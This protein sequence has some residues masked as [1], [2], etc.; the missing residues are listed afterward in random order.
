MGAGYRRWVW[1]WVG[2]CCH[3]A[4]LAK[5]LKLD[6]TLAGKIDGCPTSTYTCPAVCPGIS[7]RLRRSFTLLAHFG[8]LSFGLNDARHSALP[9][10]CSAW[11]ALA[12]TNNVTFLSNDDCSRGP[13]LMI[14]GCIPVHSR[15]AH[16]GLRYYA[17]YQKQGMGCGS[18]QCSNSADPLACCTRMISPSSASTIDVH[19]RYTAS[20]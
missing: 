9:P 19:T 2:A 16:R 3:S 15:T 18:L 4:S 5:G 17:G 11:N 8:V 20:I 6:S 14:G 1:V 13:S 10:I 7:R 12:S